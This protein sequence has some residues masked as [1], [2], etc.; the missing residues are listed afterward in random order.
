MTHERPAA[1]S[2]PPTTSLPEDFG[3]ERNWDYRYCWLR[4]AAL[5]LVLADRRRLHRRGR[6]L[7][8]LAAARRRRRPR[9]IS[10]SCTPSTAPGGCPRSPSTTC[11]ATPAP[12]RCG[13]ATRAV[14]QKQTRRARRGDGRPARRPAQAALGDTTTP[15]RCS[16]RWWPTWPTPGRS[17]DNGHLGDPRRAAALHPLPGDGL[18]GLRPRGPRR[19]GLRPARP[20]DALARLRDEVRDEVLERLRRRAQHLHAALRHARRSTRRCCCCR[21]SASSTATTRGCSA[22]SRRSRRT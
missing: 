21:W 1:S 18:G 4:D 9:P 7:A 11:P 8:G 5:T 15:G 22:P 17:R 14:D 16:G 12:G 19:R 20:V 3:G 6:L 10:R 2:P 13:S